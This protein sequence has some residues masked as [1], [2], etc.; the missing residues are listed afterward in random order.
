MHNQVFYL[1]VKTKLF[2]VKDKALNYLALPP[3]QSFLHSGQV[4]C[5]PELPLSLCSCSS[6]AWNVLS[7]QVHLG[8][9]FLSFLQDSN[10]VS[11][12]HHFSPGRVE[13]FSCI[14][15][16]NLSTSLFWCFPRGVDTITIAFLDFL[17]LQPEI[18]DAR[19]VSC[20]YCWLKQ[21]PQHQ[22]HRRCSMNVWRLAVWMNKWLSSCLQVKQD[23]NP[24]SW[25]SASVATPTKM[26]F[27]K[28]YLV[29]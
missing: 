25:L 23:S 19:N 17:C 7:I 24:N 18:F 4:S 6:P 2:S 29:F 21:P 16:N 9:L 27:L 8:M 22:A 5:S 26:L 14:T 28:V 1:W 10:H 12:L 11:Y 15:C 20:S 13:R 3:S